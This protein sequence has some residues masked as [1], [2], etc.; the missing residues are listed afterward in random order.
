[1]NPRKTDR[2]NA[3]GSKPGPSLSVR[4]A[5]WLEGGGWRAA[6]LLTAFTWVL[7]GRTLGFALHYWDDSVYIFEDPRLY[8]LTLSHL[9]EILTKP[10]FANYH[11][12]TTLTYLFDRSVW[13]QW[14]PG[15][16]LTQL[17]F[18]AACVILV[19]E[20]FRR[21]LGDRFWGLTGAALFSAHALHVEPIAWLACR[22]DVVCLVFY[23]AALL[24]YQRYAELRE[25]SS[26]AGRAWPF[27]Q[28]L[29]VIFLTCLALGSK[30]YAAVLPFV[31]LAYDLCFFTR[32]GWRQVLDKLPL[33]GLAAGLAL[34]TV[35]AQEGSSALLKDMSVLGGLT[36]YGRIEVLFKIFALYAGRSLAPLALNAQYLVSSQGWYPQWVALLGLMLSGALVSGFVF[37]RKRSPAAAFSFA[38]FCLPL[39]TT[40]NT[41]FTLRIWMTDRYLFLP[42]LGSCLLLAWAGKTLQDKWTDR[43]QAGRAAAGAVIMLALYS[44][45]TLARMNV[46]SSLVLLRSDSLRK[47]APFLGGSGPVSAD[48]FLG[49][50]RGRP[51]ALP[52]LDM[53]EELAVA[54]DREGRP[55]EARPFREILRQVGRGGINVSSKAIEEG[56][57]QDA[58]GPLTALVEKGEWEAAAAAKSLGDVY[59]KMN[60][61]EKA[62]QWYQKSFGLYKK[63]GLSGGPPL[64][65][66]MALEFSLR[67]FTRALEVLR[68]LQKEAPGDPRGL[69][70]E[71]RV[72]EETGRAD[73]AYRKYELVEKM[74]DP[75]FR[76]T[77][78]SPADVQRQM[79]I[80]AQKL[81]DTGEMRKHFSE[82][83]RLNP[84]D[85]NREAIERLL[86]AF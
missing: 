9:R 31:F 35:G 36:V 51:L 24:A 83:L 56:R 55:G 47:N 80:T 41:F 10:F 7:W 42:T 26:K 25:S 22:K 49:K 46:W 85:P 16:H 28:Y 78:L 5:L 70:F 77:Q 73:L 30:G 44:G 18:Y 27:R 37:F 48:E 60:E 53:L 40:M 79:G 33:L 76:D 63:Q 64:V 67:N 52:I 1:M 11:P 81:G 12:V 3:S 8:G 43:K 82:C 13:G 38:L 23:V 34:L 84:A 4:A 75:A 45:L 86:K 6:S 59:G 74:P 21:V 29:F 50:A 61:P 58:V 32:F 62:R 19:Y 68:L 66:E 2:R 14:I 39:A 20:L 54:Y 15:Y 71:G 72:L 17:V 65:G 57:P 69:F